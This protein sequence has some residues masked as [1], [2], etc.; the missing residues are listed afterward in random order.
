M[1]EN[2]TNIINDTLASGVE[3]LRRV[4]HGVYDG[5][6]DAPIA[7]FTETELF[8][9]ATGV[10]KDYVAAIENNDTGRRWSLSNIAAAYRALQQFAAREKKAAFVTAHVT[11][12]FLEG[13]VQGDLTKLIEQ[14]ILAEG[15][16]LAFSES[17]VLGNQKASAGVAAARAM[18]FGAAICGFSA[19]ESLSSI[20]AAPVD[21][22]FFDESMTALSGDRDKPGVFTALT[23]LLRT[24]RCSI[25]LC[26]VGSDDTIREATAAECFGI[27]PSDSYEG[28]FN[29]PKGGQ[30]MEEILSEEGAQ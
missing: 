6:D 21:Y 13:D 18:G 4:Y 5:Y 12:S 8:L 22:L 7:Y 23:A 24:L 19:K 30:T 9:T 3:P 14:G 27:M 26:G 17:A 2:V 1:L 28:E 25:V 10:M 20:V 29:F 15:V 11:K 16:V